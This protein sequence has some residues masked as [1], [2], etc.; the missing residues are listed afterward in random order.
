V[1]QGLRLE[2]LDEMV[3]ELRVL[4]R[5]E[6]LDPQRA[7]DLGDA[8]LGDEDRLVL[9]V[10][11]EVGARGLRRALRVARVRTMPSSETAML[12]RR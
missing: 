10:E 9:L 2:R 7:L 3:D 1:V 4:R 6:I 8:L 12:S 11:L 5:I